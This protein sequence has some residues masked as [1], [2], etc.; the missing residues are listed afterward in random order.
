MY[1]NVIAIVHKHI[2]NSQVYPHIILIFIWLSQVKSL[3]EVVSVAT[4]EAEQ[5][6]DFQMDTHHKPSTVKKG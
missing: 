3:K 5:A 1:I 2:C 6:G 4:K